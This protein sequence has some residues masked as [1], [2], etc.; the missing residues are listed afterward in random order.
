MYKTILFDLND[1]IATITFNRPESGNAFA[2]ESYSEIIHALKECD[3]NNNIGAVIITGNGKHFSAGGDIN[4]FKMLIETK[5]YI[6][7]ESVRAAGETALS[8]RSCS[9][10]VIAMINGAA[11]GAGCSLALACDFRI[12]SPLS[13]FLMAFIKLGLPGDTGGMYFL[14][15]LVGIAKMTEMF[16]LG[17]AVNGEEALRIGLATKL[18]EHDNLAHE[19]RNFAKKLAYGPLAAFRKQKEI[20]SIFFYPELAKF[21]RAEAVNMVEC[22][23]TGDF[24]EAVDAFLHKRQAVFS[25]K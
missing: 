3:L 11:A 25:G 9:K 4:R 8:I 10:P 7:A 13:K 18:V 19:T 14:E 6:Q 5:Q 1:K 22:S 20:M 16:L 12:V 21:I 17:E 24:A 23:R 2:K 15:K